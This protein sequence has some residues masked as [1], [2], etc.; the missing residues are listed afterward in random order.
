L[1][2]CSFFEKAAEVEFPV[3]AGVLRLSTKYSVKTFRQ[4]GLAHLT[5]AY[6]TTLE[7]WEQRHSTRT[8]TGEE[9]SPFAVLP[10]ARDA[11]VQAILPAVMYTLATRSVED[12]FDGVTWEGSH[13][14]VSV[15]DRRTCLIAR[16]SLITAKRRTISA[17]L[18]NSSDVPGCITHDV[19]NSGRLRAMF[20][21]KDGVDGCDPLWDGFDWD[22]YASNV[23]GSCLTFSTT[24]YKSARMAL[25]AELPV[26]FGLPSWVKLR[27]SIR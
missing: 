27:S 4:I 6:P 10:L 2:L 8:I 11:N 17:F 16:Q 19:C 5:S 3:L 18:K 13:F 22:E 21:N 23:C 15:S 9:P 14:A 24:S 25:W 7:A 26:I 20:T 1:T 12:I